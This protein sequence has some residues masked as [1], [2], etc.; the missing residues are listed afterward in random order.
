MAEHTF[1]L[2]PSLQLAAKR[3]YDCGRWWGA[4]SGH[5]GAPEAMCPLCAGK[6]LRREMATVRELERSNAA[7]RGALTKARRRRG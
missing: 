2:Q 5:L 3:C 6:T 1:Q 4:E 7:L